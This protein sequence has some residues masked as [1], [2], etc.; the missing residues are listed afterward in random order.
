MEVVG[1]GSWAQCMHLY[2]RTPAPSQSVMVSAGERRGMHDNVRYSP[3]ILLPPETISF[4]WGQLEINSN[5]NSYNANSR[6]IQK[7]RFSFS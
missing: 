3:L 6:P 1:W 7:F 4:F 5:S 2:L